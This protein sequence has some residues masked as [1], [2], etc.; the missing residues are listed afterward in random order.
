[1]AQFVGTTAYYTV[2][3][4][5]GAAGTTRLG[6]I[7]MKCGNYQVYAGDQQDGSDYRT[8]QYERFLRREL[9]EWVELPL[10]FEGN[11]FDVQPAG[12]GQA[13]TTFRTPAELGFTL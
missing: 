11:Q 13:T 4:R 1:M 9:T 7:Q 5:P 10:R 12:A 6:A 2:A 8:A 3:D